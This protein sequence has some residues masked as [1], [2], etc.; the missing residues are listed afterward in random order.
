MFISPELADRLLRTAS[1]SLADFQAAA[2]AL[3]PGQAAVTGDGASVSLDIPLTTQEG[4]DSEAPPQ[5]YLNVIGYIPGAGAE[6]TTASGASMDSQVVMV[7]AYY[8]GL[9]VGPDGTLYPGANDNA[10]GVATLLELARLL[11]ESPYQPKR[12]VVFVVWAGGERAEGLSVTNVMNA[13][14]GFSSLTVEDVLELSGVGAGDGEQVALGEGSSYRLSRLFQQAAS[15]LGV[16][17][18][19]R[20]RGP[21]HGMTTAPGF[22]GREALSLHLSWDGAD[23]TAHTPADTPAAIDPEK[24]RQVSEPAFMTLSVLAREATY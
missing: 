4:V 16:P 11:K 13:K 8:D 19:V 5:R 23:R 9:G 10:S 2:A 14:I 21:H 1:V 6:M 18:T 3:K 15:R 12:T 20:G 24:L 17:V 22:G 7:S